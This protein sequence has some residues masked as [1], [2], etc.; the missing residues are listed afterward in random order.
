LKFFFF[1]VSKPL[2]QHG[3]PKANEMRYHRRE[4]ARRIPRRSNQAW[5]LERTL[6][7]D[8][9]DEKKDAKIEQKKII[10]IIK[11]H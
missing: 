2:S 11:M 9:C 3:D 10:I 5:W 6:V 1:F 4:D 7:S 8:V